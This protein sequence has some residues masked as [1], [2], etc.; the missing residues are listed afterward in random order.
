MGIVK[1]EDLKKV[2]QDI[3]ERVGEGDS[4]EGNLSYTGLT[5]GLE[6]DEFEVSA[7]YRVGNLEG[8]GGMRI[9]E[10]SPLNDKGV[11]VGREDVDIE[12]QRKMDEFFANQGNQP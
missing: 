10:A 2:L 4:F 6:R 8:Q 11:I 3:A 5:P 1:R 9:I 7:A 12:N